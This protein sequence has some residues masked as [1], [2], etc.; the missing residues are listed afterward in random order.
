MMAAA[1][2]SSSPPTISR[3][4]QATFRL[5]IEEVTVP[6]CHSR[7]GVPPVSVLDA[8]SWDGGIVTDREAL[9]LPCHS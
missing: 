4:L 2:T 5:P 6:Q 9:V 7:R 3:L 8:A 1:Y